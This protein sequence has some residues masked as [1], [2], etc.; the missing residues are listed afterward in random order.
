MSKKKIY[1]V[2]INSANRDPNDNI[3]NFKVNF[4]TGEIVAKENQ[5]ITVNVLSFDMMN[6]M[7]NVNQYTGNNTFTLK[8]TNVDGISNPINTTITIPYGNYNVF[9]YMNVVNSLISPILLSYNIA[10]N[11]YTYKKTD[12][13]TYR[14]FIVP[15]NSYKFLGITTTTEITST[16]FTG[17]FVNMVNFN[18]II[19]R[20][21]NLNFDYYT[22]ENLKDDN[23][24]FE[25]SDILLWK[26]K[27]DVE[28]FKMI[29][30]N[31]EDASN[32]YIYNLYNKDVDYIDLRLTNELNEEIMDAPDYML[33]LQFIVQEKKIDIMSHNL[34]KAVELINEIKILIL[35]ALRFF[36][37]FSNI[38]LKSHIM[39]RNG[40]IHTNNS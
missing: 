22:F 34:H 12:V 28:P 10:Q 38:K 1:N 26:S 37:F 18:K 19:I 5:Y 4:L 30:Y 7:Y 3:H 9:T 35:Q 24:I 13:S 15:L 16:G 6:S 14:Y 23:N 8:R 33:S 36:G 29:S 17:S 40:T 39:N 31:N 27:Q 32:S 2:F 11:T 21:A 20:C 25:N